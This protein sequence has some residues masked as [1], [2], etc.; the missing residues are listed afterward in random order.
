MNLIDFLFWWVNAFRTPKRYGKQID[1]AQTTSI[2]KWIVY[3]YYKDEVVIIN[4]HTRFDRGDARKIVRALNQRY[5]KKRAY[6]SE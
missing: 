6:G 5:L 3:D 1:P 2:F 4:V